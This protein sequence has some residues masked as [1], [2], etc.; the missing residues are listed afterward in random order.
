MKSDDYEQGYAMHGGSTVAGFIAGTGTGV[1]KSATGGSRYQAV[2][3]DSD[4]FTEV[5]F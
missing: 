3:A 2:V 5:G 1:L 4:G